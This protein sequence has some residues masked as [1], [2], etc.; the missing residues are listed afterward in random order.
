LNEIL[1][2]LSG[3][4]LRSEG[5]AEEV[6]EEIVNRPDL[7]AA[8]AEGLQ[9][10]E[11]LIRGRTCMAMEVV[12]RGHPEILA[13]VLRPL[14]ELASQDTVPQVRWHAAEIFGNLP[15]SDGDAERIVAILLGYLEDKS[16]IVKY[17]AVQTLGALGGRSRSK[18]EIASR[19]SVLKEESK[20]L[21]KA[22]AKAMQTLGTG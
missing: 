9:S 21:A 10:D 3:G 18:K 11:K 1:K 4:D 2:K 13:G 12:S 16:K 6:A 20:G 22:V 15:L 19:I 8:L 14:I 7:V 5:S 17:C